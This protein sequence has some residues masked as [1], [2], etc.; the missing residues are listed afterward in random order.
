MSQK[1]K[2]LF[3]LALLQDKKE[4]IPSYLVKEGE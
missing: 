2:S 1:E 3:R 4:V